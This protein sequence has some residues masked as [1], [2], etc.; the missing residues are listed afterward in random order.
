MTLNT[1]HAP[2]AMGL[3]AR[4]RRLGRLAF[5][6]VI[7]NE[8]GEMITVGQLASEIHVYSSSIKGALFDCLAVHSTRE[9]VDFYYAACL[10]PQVLAAIGDD[11]AFYIC[12]EDSY[13]SRHMATHWEKV[14]D[15][16]KH[17]QNIDR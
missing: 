10:S 3:L 7:D 16:V 13:N 12:T 6:L 5:S 14:V 15:W 1:L 17:W 11:A 2:T 8:G 9:D 4:C